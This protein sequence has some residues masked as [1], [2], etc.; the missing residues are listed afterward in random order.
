MKLRERWGTLM[1][2][3]SPR[4]Q[5]Y[6]TAAAILAGGVGVMWAVLAFS[7]SD[8]PK[9]ARREAAAKEK[10]IVKPD[11]SG[12]TP[13]RV[14][15]LDQWVGTAGKELAQYKVDKEAQD[16]FNADRKAS[17]ATLME[18]LAALEQGRHESGPG[19]AASSS[20][21]ATAN[22]LPPAPA[23]AW[24]APGRAAANADPTATQGLPAQAG[25][26]MG[27]PPGSPVGPAGVSDASAPRLPVPEPPP[28]LV[29]VTLAHTGGKT[30]TDVGGPA[31]EGDE[32][33]Q[34]GEGAK[35]DTYLP[36]GFIRGE[37]LSGLAAPTGGQAQS[38]PLPVLIRL[39]DNA[40]LPNHYR[41]EVRECFVVASG[42][43][44]ISAQRAY[45]RTV[46]LSCVRRDGR[47]M[48][49]KIDGNVHGEDGMLGLP[50]RLVT[51]QGQLLANALRAG[52]VG[53]IGQGFAQ[54][55][56]TF[57][58]TP[59]GTLATTQEGTADQLKRGMA[60]GV[61]RALDNLANYYIRLA[62]QTFPVI[63]VGAKRQV[64]IVL[65]K[66]VRL[67]PLGKEVDDAH[68]D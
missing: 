25:N 52:I 36:V 55:G 10:V 39:N 67:P 20:A 34:D 37:L 50:G 43:G 66:G 11:Q 19:G 54:G 17:E 6:L 63:E 40:V 44:D 62:E 24:S 51:K 23:V 33:D 49:V 16:R 15:P 2:R 32:D 48:E 47:A 60:G 46:N 29:R 57:T 1:A 64:D 4:R 58:A 61:G 45:L 5:Q 53:G 7:A 30:R 9:P 8:A 38:N 31:A 35:L 68:D 42:Y 56:S 65:T 14:D 3:L 21:P 28:V 27:Y 18:R 41:S 22:P 59:F 12:V 26:A 13:L